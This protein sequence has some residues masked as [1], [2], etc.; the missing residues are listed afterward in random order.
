MSLIVFYDMNY[1]VFCS[2]LAY[3]Y[4]PYKVLY[5]IQDL[6]YLY[7]V[8]CKGSEDNLSCTVHYVEM[9]L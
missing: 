1:K 2:V 4:A 9:F 8:S 3:M 7:R 5:S 6:M